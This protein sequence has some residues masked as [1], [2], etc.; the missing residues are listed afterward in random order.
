M[1]SK[2]ILQCLV[3]VGASLLASNAMA[4]EIFF[5]GVK[6]TGLRNQSFQG[7]KVDFDANGNVLITAQG[8]AV[9]KME[10]A[11]APPPV[12]PPVRYTPVPPPVAPPP[13]PPPQPKPKAPAMPTASYK[14]QF[15][16]IALPTKVGYTQYDI[17]VFFN[18]KWVRKVRNSDNQVRM[19]VSKIISRGKNVIQYAATKNYSGKERLSESGDDNIRVIIGTGTA[20]GGT[21]NI[22]EILADYQVGADKTNNFNTEKSFFVK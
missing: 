15:F 21:M 7:C 2:N 11:P 18:G 1:K 20:G 17:D 13:T 14:S 5:N 8:Y 19:D 6:V 4:V 3:I 22:T 10:T 9:Q 12:A 16:L